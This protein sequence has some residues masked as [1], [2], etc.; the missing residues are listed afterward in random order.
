MHTHKI[1]CSDVKAVLDQSQTD[2]DTSKTIFENS[3]QL[4][5]ITIIPWD[6]LTVT[7]L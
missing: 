6:T 5:L 1:L 7:K 2:G 4:V 3:R